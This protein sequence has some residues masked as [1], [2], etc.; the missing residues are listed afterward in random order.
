MIGVA[1]ALK[2]QVPRGLVVLKAGVDRDLAQISAE[3]VER[4]RS[5]LG[6]VASLRQIDVVA[7]LP[8]T[9]SGKQNEIYGGRVVFCDGTSCLVCL[10]DLLDQGQLGFDGLGD[11]HRLADR[12]IYGVD[13]AALRGTGPSVVSINAVVASLA[14]TEFMVLVT[15]LRESSAQLTYRADVGIVRKSVDIPGPGCYYCSGL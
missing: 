11:E 15:G 3:L 7:A 13:R 8:K 10:P 1:D 12:R 5:Q 4:V 9:R 2:G 14:V 6:A